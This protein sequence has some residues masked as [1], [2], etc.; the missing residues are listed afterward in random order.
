MQAA[1]RLNTYVRPGGRI[2]FSDD[3]LTEGKAVEVIVLLQQGENRSSH[4]ITDVLARAP[5][6]LTFKTAAEVDAYLQQERQ[7]WER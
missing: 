2:E 3:Q 6:H 1:L 7:E 4:S 5:G